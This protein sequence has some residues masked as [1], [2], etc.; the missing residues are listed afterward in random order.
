MWALLKPLSEL[1]PGSKGSHINHDNL[2]FRFVSK[3][4]VI[5]CLIFATL[6]AMENY[7]GKP[8]TCLSPKGSTAEEMINEFCWIHGTRF[9]PSSQWKKMMRPL[10]G[11][12]DVS[13]EERLPYNPF[14]DLTKV[15]CQHTFFLKT[16][17]TDGQWPWNVFSGGKHFLD[18]KTTI[19]QVR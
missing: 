6:A 17:E 18:S 7:I 14:C 4:S 12:S 15:T 10:Y 5:L 1:D 9:I 3:I 19:F 2:K 13:R 16:C 8:I 11:D